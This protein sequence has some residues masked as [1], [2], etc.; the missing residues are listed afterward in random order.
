MKEKLRRRVRTGLFALGGII[1]GLVYYYFF[2]CTTGCAI[3]S[4]PLMTALYMG[5]I[6][7]LLGEITRVEREER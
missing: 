6:G 1:G 5:V 4:S 7:C 2:G 3:T